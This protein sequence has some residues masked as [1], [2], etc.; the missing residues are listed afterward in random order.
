[1]ADDS[2]FDALR[3]LAERDPKAYFAE[4]ARIIEAFFETVPI[5]R[6][7]QLR[8]FQ[9]DLDAVRAAAGTP[10]KAVDNLMGML[11]EHLEAL[12]GHTSQ[13]AHEARDMRMA[14]LPSLRA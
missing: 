1:M 6:Q 10:A 12:L 8:Q 2:D 11:S 4:R 14:T 5:E 7:G 13:L 9:A 3:I